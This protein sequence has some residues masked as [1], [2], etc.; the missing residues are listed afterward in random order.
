MFRCQ[1]VVRSLLAVHSPFSE[2]GCRNGARQLF[3][4]RTNGMPA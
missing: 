1:R 4:A 3:H 2:G